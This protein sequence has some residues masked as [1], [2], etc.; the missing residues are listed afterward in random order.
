MLLTKSSRLYIELT[1]I[2]YVIEDYGENLLREYTIH[3]FMIQ[4][5]EVFVG[6]WRIKAKQAVSERI[7]IYSSS[8]LNQF[9]LPALF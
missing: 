4:L 1:L 3:S 9:I 7:E 5:T 6:Y 2:S 8:G